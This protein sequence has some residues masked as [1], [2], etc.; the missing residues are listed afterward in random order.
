MPVTLPQL[1]GS[2]LITYSSMRTFKTCPRKFLYRYEL[3]IRRTDEASYF[4]FGRA[5]HVGLD[6]RAKG[7]E[8]ADAANAALEQWTRADLI[9]AVTVREL[10]LG[11]WWWWEEHAHDAAI[12]VVGIVESERAF[13]MAIPGHRTFHAAGK[14]DRIV[15]VRDGR[16]L[17]MEN[18]TTSD[19]LEPSSD[20]W[21]RLLID[22]QIS[23]YLLAARNDGHDVSSVLYDAIRKPGI[24]PKIIDRKSGQRES[25]DEFA[26]RLAADIRERPAFYF[27]RREIPRLQA[28]LDE[29][30]RDLRQQALS[31]RHAQRY[32]HFY[33]NTAACV[34][35]G[36]CEYLDSCHSG[37]DPENLPGN[38]VRVPDIHPELKG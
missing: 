33:R 19:S 29:F 35:F 17:L 10:L 6:A 38:F 5:V 1:P 20:Y 25:A 16:T 31:I 24:A 34:G 32:G 11:Y 18:K 2:D 21:K 8:R 7:A 23:L 3:G 30:A 28:D 4:G 12:D 26:A 36:T 37:L 9:D 22:E 13:S 15:T 14:R 27:A